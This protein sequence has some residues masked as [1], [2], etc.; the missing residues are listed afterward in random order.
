MLQHPIYIPS[1]RRSTLCNTAKILDSEGIPYKIFV[2]PQEQE[3]YQH[4]YPGRCVILDKN[5][6]G[7]AY[8]RSWIKTYSRDRGEP[9]HWQLDD[10]IQG[11]LIRKGTANKKSTGLYNLTQVEMTCSKYR[12]IGL[13]GLIHNMFAFSHRQ[14]IGL[15][16][17]VYTCILVNNSL[18]I[19][20]RKGVVEDT[21]YSLQVLMYQRRQWCILAF[22][23]LLVVKPVTMSM[24]GG[25]TEFEYGPDST[26]GGDGR[27]ARAEGLQRMW[28]GWFKTTFQYG[29]VKMLPSQIWRQ[30][31]QQ[32]IRIP[33]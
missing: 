3:V 30:F 24:E 14:A 1:K 10:N 28:P 23:R 25:C 15:N 27:K 11:F 13:A 4:I 20:W 18:N 19:F 17:Q 9:F 2:E 6:Q 22:H 5:D 32:P 7:V 29:R 26:Y 33:E 21:D 16:K 31:T 8:V 12:N